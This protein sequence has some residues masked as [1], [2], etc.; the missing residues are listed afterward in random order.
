MEFLL[1]KR[2]RQDDGKDGLG[3]HDLIGADCRG[4]TAVV[5]RALGCATPLRTPGQD[6]L[7][8]RERM[9]EDVQAGP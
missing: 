2:L 3:L 7:W 8:R 5:R 4:W 9:N 1:T 6:D